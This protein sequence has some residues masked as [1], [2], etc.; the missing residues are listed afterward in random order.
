MKKLILTVLICFSCLGCEN[1]DITIL[2]KEINTMEVK[3]ED[4]LESNVALEES[5]S[6]KDKM[7]D[8]LQSQINNIENVHQHKKIRV[9]SGNSSIL[10]YYYIED[11]GSYH[12]VTI[13]GDDQTGYFDEKPNESLQFGPSSGNTVTVSVVGSIYNVRYVH[14][15][16]NE[17]FTEK[18]IVETFNE[19][20]VVRDSTINIESLVPE[21]IPYEMLIWENSKGEKFEYI[22][23]EN[24]MVNAGYVIYS[25]VDH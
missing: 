20:D 3:Y 8:L 14:F 4:L 15:E 23:Q 10:T 7:I 5:L 9:I 6:D 18:K 16:Y 11:D 12:N 13:L 25:G 17:K 2:E 22:I 1:N 21:G 24:G 19:V